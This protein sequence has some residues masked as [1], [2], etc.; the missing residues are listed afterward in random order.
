[1]GY[2]ETLDHDPW[3]PKE[4][5]LDWD[6]PR[7]NAHLPGGEGQAQLKQWRDHDLKNVLDELFHDVSNYTVLESLVFEASRESKKG[8]GLQRDYIHAS[9]SPHSSDT[10]RFPM[11][12][13]RSHSTCV[14]RRCSQTRLRISMAQRT[15]ARNS[16]PSYRRSGL[17]DCACEKCAQ[18]SSPILLLV[19]WNSQSS[20]VSL[21]SSTSPCFQTAT[22]P[23]TFTCNLAHQFEVLLKAPICTNTCIERLGR[24]PSELRKRTGRLQPVQVWISYVFPTY[25]LPEQHL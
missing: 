5:D 16:P 3:H 14:A 1:M 7:K 18:L 17:S 24:S 10:C 20:R 15:S 11:V 23:P 6:G 25:P 22:A 2:A 4:T 19:K 21:S 8:T 12:C 9:P 13:L